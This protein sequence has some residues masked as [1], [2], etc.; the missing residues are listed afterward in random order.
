M[1]L[2]SNDRSHHLP[3]GTAIDQM[4]DDDR[5]Y[6]FRRMLGDLDQEIAG[7][8]FGVITAGKNGKA[9]KLKL[10]DDRR[11]RV[12]AVAEDYGLSLG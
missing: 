4:S 9:R 8:K 11:R 3:T 7:V 2:K 10:M 6:M 5:T 1:R 12:I